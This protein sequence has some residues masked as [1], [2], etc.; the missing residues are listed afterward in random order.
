MVR[1]VGEEVD[2]SPDVVSFCWGTL[3]PGFGTDVDGRVGDTVAGGP[4]ILLLLFKDED[5]VLTVF[6]NASRRVVT[7]LNCCPMVCIKLYKSLLVGRVV[8]GSPRPRP[9]PRPSLPRPL[10]I[11]FGDDIVVAEQGI[12]ARGIILVKNNTIK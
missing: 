7:V 12:I 11:A 2:F 3:L 5:D 10:I 9:R 1:C 4:L 8:G 6:S